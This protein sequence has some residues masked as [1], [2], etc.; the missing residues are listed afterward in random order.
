M[1]TTESLAA[2]ERLHE[3][4]ILRALASGRAISRADLSELVGLGRSSVSQ[5]LSR[6]VAN[7]TVVVE[8]RQKQ[9]GRG[10]PTERLSID[11]VAVAA[12]GI[13]FGHGWVHVSALNILGDVIGRG[14]RSIGDEA[15]W[16]ARTTLAR[17]LLAGLALDPAQ[18]RPLRAIAVGLPGP[19][20]IDRQWIV[21]DGVNAPVEDASD[22]YGDAP[23]FGFVRDTARHLGVPAL[24]D[25]TS[26]FAAFAEHVA[27]GGN[28]E[29]TTFYV[30]CFSGIGGALASQT[31]VVRGSSG[32]A[33]EIGHLTVEPD[34]VK[35]R[36]GRR[37][38]LET[39]AT[40]PAVLRRARDAGLDVSDVGELAA[41]LAAGDERARAALTA[42][43]H[44]LGRALVSVSLLVDPSHIIV[45]GEIVE[46]DDVVLETARTT[47]REGLGGRFVPT[48]IGRGSLGEGAAAV[49]AALTVLR[50]ELPAAGP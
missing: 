16:E 5:I 25:N 6:L 20:H 14:G 7:G 21:P 12:I 22:R 32:M 44:A 23:W 43:G 38:C 37:G 18:L 29:D 40:T 2:I 50:L 35:C 27:R 15:T 45:S 4:E 39:V 11:P 46:I 13:D 48:P 36:C 24:L 49:G 41:A 30:R 17:S 10:R 19:L 34:G 47:Y 9:S 8:S 28:G 1:L 26:R 33:G 42:A 31:G 3:A